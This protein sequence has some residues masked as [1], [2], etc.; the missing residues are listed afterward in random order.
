[1]DKNKV[2]IR[3]GYYFLTVLLI[4]L[5]VLELLSP[6]IILAYFNLNYLIVAWL[7]FSVLELYQ[8]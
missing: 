5:V 6:N 1:M 7:I 4:V 2:L 3:E 8:K